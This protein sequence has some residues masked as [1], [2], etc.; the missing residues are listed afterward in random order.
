MG[1]AGEK[2]ND[3]GTSPPKGA[4]A[5]SAAP[6]G[7]G[8]AAVGAKSPPGGGAEARRERAWISK[9]QM[10]LVWDVSE[11]VFDRNIRPH[12]PLDC[13]RQQKNRV[14]FYSR[15]CIEGYLRRPL[16][17]DAEDAEMYAGFDSPAL[18]KF[19]EA[20]AGLAN[21]DLKEREKELVSRT[22]MRTGLARLGALYRGVGEKLQRKYG[23]EAADL[24]NEVMDE[25]EREFRGMFGEEE[26][27]GQV[28][29]A[30]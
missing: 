13:V 3:I 2:Q 7:K 16:A 10:L 27:H 24:L 6:V 26:D 5:L 9:G 11:Q 23:P 8:T 18:E 30:T 12:F 15:G 1:G 29:H 4:S 17:V 21:L 22:D 14:W 20:R 28:A 19:R 25:A